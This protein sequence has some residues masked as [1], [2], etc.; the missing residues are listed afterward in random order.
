MEFIT[1]EREVMLANNIAKCL[2][3][4]VDEEGRR[5]MLLSEI[6]DHR[7]DVSAIPISEGTFTTKYGSV[8][9]K[10]TTGSCTY[11]GRM[12]QGTGFNSRT[13]RILIRFNSPIMPSVMD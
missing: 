5:Q 8:R 7:V 4:Q 2:L 3:S 9:K 1:G 6:V 11:N 12:V 13:L 10:R